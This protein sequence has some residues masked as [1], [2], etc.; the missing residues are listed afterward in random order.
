MSDF[1]RVTLAIAPQDS[2]LP[3]GAGARAKSAARFTLQ[4][5]QREID[6]SPHAAQSTLLSLAE[7][8]AMSAHRATLL[9]LAERAARIQTWAKADA[10]RQQI[11]TQGYVVEDRPDGYRLKPR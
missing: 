4:T 1:I 2:P 8:P 10:L 7:A 5:L 3:E 6:S 11:L 9:E